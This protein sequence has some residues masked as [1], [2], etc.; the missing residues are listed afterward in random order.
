MGPRVGI[1]Y[2]T[3]RNQ[4]GSALKGAL[5]VQQVV[6]ETARRQMAERDQLE[7]ETQ[8]AATLQSSILPKNLNVDGLEIAAIMLPAGTTGGDY[9]DVLVCDDGCWL[10]IGDVAGEGLQT[11]LM[12]MMIQSVVAAIV[13]HRPGTRPSEILR[14]LN[15]V[16]FENMRERLHRDERATSTLLH[17][18]R[19]GRVM[20]AGV[21]ENIIVYRAA[22]G[23]CDLMTSPG[24]WVTA[25]TNPR[26]GVV[27]TT[28]QLSDGDVMVLYT[29]G[30]VNSR[31]AERQQF[32]TDRL[33]DLLKRTAIAT[34]DQIRDQ[35]VDAIRRFAA[36]RDDD[37][38]LVVARFCAS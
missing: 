29:D 26:A 14:V 4:I 9:Y 3:M 32:G 18:V 15:A 23:R 2:E 37:V 33:C 22:E 10:G 7:R 34:V 1:V 12:I 19:S 24:A 36:E 25:D 17:Y 30:A 6:D 16:L 11:S 28:F 5:L 31:N 35:L 13:R 8:I 38:T 20:F 21:R 27:D